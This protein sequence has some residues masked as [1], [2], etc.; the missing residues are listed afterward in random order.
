M[1]GILGENLLPDGF[2]RWPRCS[3]AQRLIVREAANS[4]LAVPIV[5]SAGTTGET[6]PPPLWVRWGTRGLA[7]HTFEATCALESPRSVSDA[8][9]PEPMS[10][11]EDALRGLAATIR[12]GVALGRRRCRFRLPPNLCPDKNLG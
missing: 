4:F 6:G 8:H 9:P 11:Q 1:N 3:K 2:R 10:R 5:A 12:G 7:P